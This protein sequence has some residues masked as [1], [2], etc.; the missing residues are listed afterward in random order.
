MLDQIEFFSSMVVALGF[1][2]GTP[3][4]AIA[5]GRIT[6]TVISPSEIAVAFAITTVD[7]GTDPA[8]LIDLHEYAGAGELRDH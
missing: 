4:S 5:C 7:R 6:P 3:P 2:S 1:L 8:D